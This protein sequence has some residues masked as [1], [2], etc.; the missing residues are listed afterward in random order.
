MKPLFMTNNRYHQRAK[1]FWLLPGCLTILLACF[2]SCNGWIRRDSNLSS[3]PGGIANVGQTCYW[4]SFMQNASVHYPDMFDPSRVSDPKSKKLVEE[5]RKAIQAINAGHEIES[6]QA[7]ILFNALSAVHNT[8]ERQKTADKRMNEWQQNLDRWKAWNVY[9]TEHVEEHQEEQKQKSLAKVFDLEIFDSS[10]I[11]DTDNKGCIEAQRTIIQGLILNGDEVNSDQ[12]KEIFDALE[13]VHNAEK[14]P[15]E[16]E[17]NKKNWQEAYELWI[18]DFNAWTR[19]KKNHDEWEQQPEKSRGAAPQKPLRKDIA[20]QNDLIDRYKQGDA[21]EMLVTIF[22]ALQ[23]PTALSTTL[24]TNPKDGS[25]RKKDAPPDPWHMLMLPFPMDDYGRYPEEANM[26]TLVKE[27]FKSSEVEV[28]W[29]K[30]DIENTKV[31]SKTAVANLSELANGILPILVQRNAGGRV[32]TKLKNAFTIKLKKDYV[33]DS[34]E[35]LFYD[36][37]GFMLQRG[38]SVNGGHYVAWVY[39][40]DKYQ[41]YYISDTFVEEKTASE[42]ATAAENAYFFFYQPR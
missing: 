31:H 17:R 1:N 41:W 42:A 23:F 21:Q 39:K 3:Q 29:E 38:S 11:S 12:S 32:N 4:N 27:Y 2:V 6:G 9:Y 13:R 33:E 37:Q 16:A 24:M 19:W 36:L 7:T 35:D 22:D 40:K 5:C 8:D 10:N 34:E 30:E 20:P 15:E 14:D 28:K 25:Q 18:N 26:Q